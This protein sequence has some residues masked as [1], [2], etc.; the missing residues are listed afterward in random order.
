MSPASPAA[1]S[2]GAATAPCPEQIAAVP[3]LGRNDVY[4][5]AKS[6][7][8]KRLW[9]V[10]ANYADFIYYLS[11][12]KAVDS[13]GVLPQENLMD[14]SLSDMAGGKT[15]L[16]DMEVFF[17][18]FVDIVKSATHTHFPVEVLDALS[19]EDT[20]D[21]HHV[22][23]NEEFTEKYNRIQEKTKEGLALRDP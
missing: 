1:D 20:L 11:G 5:I 14:F 3:R 7:Q 9:E 8:D 6:T 22:A 21:L 10:L 19:V 16:S 4:R 2:D 12:A 15:H 17:K 13:E 18:M 23:V